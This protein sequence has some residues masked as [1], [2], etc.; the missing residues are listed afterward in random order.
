M[1]EFSGKEKMSNDGEVIYAERLA[2]CG[3][4]CENMIRRSEQNPLGERCPNKHGE[5]RHDGAEKRS[6]VM[7]LPTK[8]NNRYVLWCQYCMGGILPAEI[9]YKTRIKPKN[10]DAG[11]QSI[12]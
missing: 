5:R 11:Q 3:R 10:T 4:Q 12:L 2:A 8:Y 9:G 1:A 7:L 6:R